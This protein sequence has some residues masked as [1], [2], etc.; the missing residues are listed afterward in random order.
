M[1]AFKAGNVVAFKLDSNVNFSLDNFKGLFTENL[2]RHM[3]PNTF[4]HRFDH[5]GR[6]D[7]YYRPAGYALQ[8]LQLLASVKRSSSWLSKWCQQWPLWSVF[9]VMAL[10]W[11]PLTIAVLIF[12]CRWCGNPGECLVTKGYFDTV[13]N[14]SDESGKT[15]WVQDTLPL[16]AKSFSSLFAQWLPYKHSGPSWDFRDYIL[17]SFCF[18]RRIL[19]L[20]LV[21]KPSSTMRRIED[22]LSAGAIPLLN[23]YTL[24]LLCKRTVSGSHKR[25]RQYIFFNLFWTCS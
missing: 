19:Q 21:Y 12:L 10:C 23:L 18:V 11:T 5:Y 8:P 7:K 9:F 13:P 2:V 3:V 16:L 25:W 14:V 1:S 17:S 6:S 20:P 15:G 4:D 24:L 22:C